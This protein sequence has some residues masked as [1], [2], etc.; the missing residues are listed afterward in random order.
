MGNFLN[1]S[2]KGLLEEENKQFS[3]RQYYLYSEVSCKY[4]MKML[5]K[6]GKKKGLFLYLYLSGNYNGT[7]NTNGQ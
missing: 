2:S 1:R 3:A 6:L 4:G 7:K 5:K